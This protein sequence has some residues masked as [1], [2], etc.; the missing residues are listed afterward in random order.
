METV[1]S[2]PDITF[3]AAE[4]FAQNLG[5]SR[6]EFYTRAISFYLQKSKEYSVT[7]RLNKIYGKEAENSTLAPVLQ[8]LQF[9]ALSQREW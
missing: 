6:S 8:Q 3:Q 5:I 4:Q 1:L 2:I 9:H 7:E